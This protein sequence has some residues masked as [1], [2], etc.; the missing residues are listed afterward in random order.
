MGPPLSPLSL[1]VALSLVFS[2]ISA[3]VS[4]KT[5]LEPRNV[6][7]WPQGGSKIVEQCSR[8]VEQLLAAA[9]GCVVEDALAF[10]GHPVVGYVLLAKV[11]G[12]YYLWGQ[13]KFFRKSWRGRMLVR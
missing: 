5:A 11:V 4:R 2:L 6:W 7:L 1:S 8:A 9:V 13:Q 3:P 12:S 10:L